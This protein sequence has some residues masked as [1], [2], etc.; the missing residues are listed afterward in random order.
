M[1]SFHAF[2]PSAGHS[3]SHGIHP[4]ESS[5]SSGTK[6]EGIGEGRSIPLLVTPEP[7]PF[8]LSST[9]LPTSGT[10]V[11]STLQKVTSPN[12]A[13]DYVIKMSDSPDANGTRP[14]YRRDDVTGAPQATQ[15][16]AH[17]DGQGGWKIVSEANSARPASRSNLPPAANVDSKQLGTL[18]KDG[19]YPGGDGHSYVH[20]TDG[21]HPVSY[22]HQMGGWKIVDPDK[23][24]DFSKSMP[25][26]L[27]GKGGADV[28]PK[29]GLP[30]GMDDGQRPGPSKPSGGSHHPGRLT[31][32]LKTLKGD[33]DKVQ[34]KLFALN[35]T[36][37]GL[38]EKVHPLQRE[39]A[40]LEAKMKNSR[41]VS[42]ADLHQQASLQRQV[43]TLHH[44]I[45]SI[46]YAIDTTGREL[47]QIERK[48]SDTQ[49]HSKNLPS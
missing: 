16:R 23:P 14:V 27:D 24:N 1:P 26:K 3:S 6:P 43:D 25:V 46:Q 38:N 13:G 49:S 36:K 11:K 42:L 35:I 20:M 18:N 17:A 28:L 5:H 8:P 37:D 30:G 31:D 9:G 44:E 2:S 32:E 19:V 47:G 7:N 33:H 40:Q 48:I 10:P 12:K 22:D 34:R 4:D 21:Y 41:Y 15:E 39:L 45:D 29:A